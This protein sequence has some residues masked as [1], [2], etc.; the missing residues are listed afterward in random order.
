[1]TQ[2]D[3]LKG[4]GVKEEI[5]EEV[6]SDQ[7]NS[8]VKELHHY[9]KNN[10]NSKVTGVVRHRY[11]GGVMTH[12][13][14]DNKYEVRHDDQGAKLKSDHD[15]AKRKITHKDVLVKRGVVKEEELDEAKDHAS[16]SDAELKKH[17][18]IHTRN[19]LAHNLSKAASD[20]LRAAQAELKKRRQKR[21][22]EEAKLDE[23]QLDEGIKSVVHNYLAKRAGKKADD[24]YDMGDEKEFQKQVD[25]S[26]YH[27][28]KAGGK[29]TRINKNP[30]A[31]FL[32]TIEEVELDESVKIID[33]DSDL[34]QEHFKLSVN[35]KPVH[36]VHH[37]YEGGHAT[38][39]KQDIH[40]QVKNQLKHLSD[41]DKKK[42]TDTVHASYRMKEEAELSEG[43]LMVSRHRNYARPGQG[44]EA[45]PIT[46]DHGEA[47]DGS[48][49]YSVKQPNGFHGVLAV[50]GD[51]VVGSS[52]NNLSKDEAH[53]MGDH[54]VKHGTV[55]IGVGKHWSLGSG[56]H[57]KVV[58]EE[59]EL[60]ESYVGR[61]TKDGVWRVFKTG[62]PVAVAGPFKSSA[63]ASAWIRSHAMS[64]DVDLDEEQLDELKSST[65]KSYADKRMASFSRTKGIMPGSKEHEQW[66]MAQKAYD[67]AAAKRMVPSM[68]REEAELDE[69]VLSEAKH[70]VSVTVSEPD[71][72]AVSMRKTTKQKT[73][74]VSADDKVSA[75]ARAKAHYKKQGYKV[76]D[77]EH[78]GMVSEETGLGEAMISYSDFM[79]KIAMHRK[80]GNKVVD[81]KYTD[82]KATYTTVDSEG[83]GKKITHTETGTKQEHL[84]KIEGKDDE[85]EV[86]QPEKRG[87]GRPAGTKSGARH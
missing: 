22:A 78:V 14:I 75:V 74:R 35:G 32:T 4:R 38:D 81:H 83:V 56:I 58:K 57:G 1:M 65:L 7:S 29:P 61:E 39:S 11:G 31:K 27:R 53:K 44:P 68:A 12:V 34:D 63:D 47:S 5:E 9:L 16:M 19:A 45:H 79:D 2:A 80:M 69:D 51:T 24:A 15:Y 33:R 37:N 76:H 6:G 72:P 13:T 48:R 10:P 71:H 46:K 54:Y 66:K 87:R 43:T 20:N 73:I 18:S 40:Y 50:K 77:A 55:G 30:D 86:K 23:E 36:F 59:F 62:N 84:G 67:K 25:K 26:E 82:K 60:S 21:V 41:A 49:V 17:I 70:R 52:Q 28:V 8:K 85:A 3:V 64:E 42:V